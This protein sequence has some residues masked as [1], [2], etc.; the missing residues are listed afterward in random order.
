VIAQAATSRE[1]AVRRSFRLSKRKRKVHFGRFLTLRHAPANGGSLRIAVVH[2]VVF[3]RQ[4]PQAV[5]WR[6]QAIGFD[7]GG[8][9]AKTA[10]IG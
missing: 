2:G 5:T 1:T 9:T 10:R 8:Q 3:A 7:P 4:Q 6:K